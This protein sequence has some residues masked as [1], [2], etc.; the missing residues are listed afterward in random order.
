M[1][2]CTY[3]NEHFDFVNAKGPFYFTFFMGDTHERRN[4]HH[5]ELNPAA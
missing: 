5:V 4:A 3:S 1:E 2:G